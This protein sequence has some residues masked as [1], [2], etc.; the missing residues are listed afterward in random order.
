MVNKQEPV[1]GRG[2]FVQ[3]GQKADGVTAA[4][5]GPAGSHACELS[6]AQSLSQWGEK[7]ALGWEG[8]S[9]GTPPPA[10]SEARLQALL[11][12]LS[13]QRN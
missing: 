9:P 1:S 13:E 8:V 7:T 3:W 10:P 2:R 6:E 12:L 4:G 11:A 5:S